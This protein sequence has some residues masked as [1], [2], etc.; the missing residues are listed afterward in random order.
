[1]RLQFRDGNAA[2]IFVIPLCIYGWTENGPPLRCAAIAASAALSLV[3]GFQRR[4]VIK[5]SLVTPFGVNSSPRCKT[6]LVHRQRADSAHLRRIFPDVTQFIPRDRPT[7]D[8]TIHH[9][10]ISSI[11]EFDDDVSDGWCE[12]TVANQGR[13][14]I[15]RFDLP[16][17]RAIADRHQWMLFEGTHDQID[18][19]PPG[20]VS[21]LFRV[22]AR[23]AGRNP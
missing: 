19:R 18:R 22:R 20:Q 5:T 16:V 6:T 2:D 7:G 3:V 12:T 8:I 10:L 14:K 21:G 9:R 15:P 17:P 1:M 4:T 11:A 13:E 23:R